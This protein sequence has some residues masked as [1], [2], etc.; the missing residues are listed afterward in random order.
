MESI[1]RKIKVF[2]LDHRDPILF[3]S[4]VI[5]GIIIVVQFLNQI[6][7]QKSEEET[8]SNSVD[9]MTQNYNNYSADDKKLIEDFISFCKKKELENAYKL[10]S[11]KCKEQ[12]YPT[13][14]S[15]EQEYYNKIFKQKKSIDIQYDAQQNVYKITFSPDLLES[16]KLTNEN[17]IVDYYKVEEEVIETKIF[18]NYNKDI[19]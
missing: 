3:Y 12:L 7:I 2:W 5:I 19:K 8:T 9:T 13:I 18:I 16:G 14:N 6:A 15:F 1:R 10:L 4:M 17:N 11:N